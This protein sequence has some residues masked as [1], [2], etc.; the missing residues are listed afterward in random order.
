[1]AKTTIIVS[2]D[3]NLNINAMRFVDTEMTMNETLVLT[4]LKLNATEITEYDTSRDDLE[5]GKI[6][7]FETEHDAN[8]EYFFRNMGARKCD[9]CGKWIAPQDIHTSVWDR[10]ESKRRCATCVSIYENNRPKTLKV[11]SY[12]CCNYDLILKK[13]EN[14]EM[15][16]ANAKAIGIEMEICSS[17]STS[18]TRGDKIK[19]TDVFYKENKDS[20]R[21]WHME[22][23]GSLSNGVEFISQP[24]S[25]AYAKAYDWSNLTNQMKHL[26]C[27]DSHRGSGFHV[28]VSKLCF[29]DDEKTQALNALKLYYVM[30]IYQNDFLKVSGRK[31]NEMHYCRFLSEDE[32]INIKNNIARRQS[33]YF[34]ALPYCHDTCIINSGKTIEI[35]IFKSTSDEA[36]LKH[37][38]ALVMG[39]VENIQNVPFEKIYC[40]RKL[41]KNVPQET[42]AYWRQKGAFLHTYANTK[43]GETI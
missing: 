36:R 38:L 40:M 1:M 5:S 25:F 4:S 14:E 3:T 32:V 23:D 9:D 11:F 30:A 26:Q 24:M 37:T 29:G 27:N 34:S 19:C 28:H 10:E 12:H 6:Y 42:M 43:K 17:A 21:V 2:K 18:I 7:Y 39:I 13:L 20:K 41:F 8:A 15:T 31:L 16:M 22:Y 33:S 35:R